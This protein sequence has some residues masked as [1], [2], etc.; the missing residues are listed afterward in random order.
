[1]EISKTESSLSQTVLAWHW[2]GVSKTLAYAPYT[3]VSVG[4]TL[5]ATEKPLELCAYGLHASL[6]LWDSLMYAPGPVL[7]RVELSGEILYS[8]D[9][10]CASHRRV[11]TMHDMTAVLQEFACRCAEAA[12]FAERE[13]GREPDARSWEVI[14]VAR[15]HSRG[16]A[17]NSEM[18]A[19]ASAAKSA[20]ESAAASAAASAAWSAYWTAAKSAAPDAAKSAAWSAADHAYWTAAK[21]AAGNAR[22][23]Q[24]KAWLL[25]MVMVEMEA[26]HA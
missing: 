21:S 16:E 26:A 20:A 4:Q 7:C 12:L 23:S 1:M 17:D 22:L 19:A 15:R 10:L 5:T 24:F 6:D 13:A 2:L 18:K 25:E 11:L 3:A 8:D 9:K 14:E